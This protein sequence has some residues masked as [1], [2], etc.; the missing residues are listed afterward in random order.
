M[1]NKER[2]GMPF[3]LMTDEEQEFLEGFPKKYL[4]FWYF[5]NEWRAITNNPPLDGSVSYRVKENMI[6]NNL[7]ELQEFLECFTTD[8]YSFIAVDENLKVFNYNYK[9]N[10]NGNGWVN[11]GSLKHI[12]TLKPEQLNFNFD[13]SETW[14]SKHEDIL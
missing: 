4:E 11:H 10:V 12:I 9:P 3:G 14:F 7:Y 1:I 6:F 8:D 2:I 5:T 13:W